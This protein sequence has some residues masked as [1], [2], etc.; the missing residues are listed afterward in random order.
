MADISVL[1]KSLKYATTSKRISEIINTPQ[2]FLNL[3]QVT[4]SPSLMIQ[5]I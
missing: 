1:S 3:K 5:G 4:E 2:I